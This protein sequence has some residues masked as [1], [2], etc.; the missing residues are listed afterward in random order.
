MLEGEAQDSTMNWRIAD[1]SWRD[2]VHLDNKGRSINNQ[3]KRCKRKRCKKNTKE[4]GRKRKK[5]QKGKRRDNV[6]LFTKVGMRPRQG[7]WDQHTKCRYKILFFPKWH[8]SLRMSLNSSLMSWTISSMESLASSLKCLETYIFPMAAEKLPVAEL[9][10]VF[11][12]GLVVVFPVIF[13]AYSSL[14]SLAALFKNPTES[15]VACQSI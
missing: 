10:Q 11:H 5:T 8:T 2:L 14:M 4:K 6:F 1:A 3:K 13:L 15:L 9:R 7:S 12:L